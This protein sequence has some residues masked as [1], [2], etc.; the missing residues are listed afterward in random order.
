MQRTLGTMINRLF[1]ISVIAFLAGGFILTFG[2][3]AGVVIGDGAILVALENVLAVPTYVCAA[4]AGL[5][6]FIEMYTSK[7][8]EGSE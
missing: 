8:A 3:L 5:L 7:P 2:Q 6:A 1:R 4:I